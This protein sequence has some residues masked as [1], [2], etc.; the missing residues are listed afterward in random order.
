M[1]GISDCT[2]FDSHHMRR[3]EYSVGLG[4]FP[5]RCAC[6]VGGVVHA[7]TPELRSVVESPEFHPQNHA[8]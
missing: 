1:R 5:T 7:V 2:A 4:G 3:G 6:G 8:A